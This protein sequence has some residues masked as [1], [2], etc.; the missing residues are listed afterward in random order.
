[1]DNLMSIEMLAKKLT[2]DVVFGQNN[3]FTF[4]NII[5]V[6]DEN[7]VTYPYIVHKNEDKVLALKDT[8]YMMDFEFE[9]LG[10]TKIISGYFSMKVGE[11]L[12]TMQSEDG[13]D[14]VGYTTISPYVILLQFFKKSEI[15]MIYPITYV[16]NN[17]DSQ[18]TD[19]TEGL[20]IVEDFMSGR[21]HYGYT[22]I[23]KNIWFK[24]ESRINLTG[25][26]REI[27]SGFSIKKTAETFAMDD[28]VD[29][30]KPNLS[31]TWDPTTCLL[32]VNKTHPDYEAVDLI[33]VD[34]YY[35]ENPEKLIEDNLKDGKLVFSYY[36]NMR[37]PSICTI[38]RD[39]EKDFYSDDD[40]RV[41]YEYDDFG[42][43]TAF[44]YYMDGKLEVS[45]KYHTAGKTLT[46]LEIE[47][48]SIDNT[49]I[50]T[51][52]SDPNY[53]SYFSMDCSFTY[54]GHVKN[55]PNLKSYVYTYDNLYVKSLAYN[56]VRILPL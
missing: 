27:N 48:S 23:F 51:C 8:T 45:A 46:L 12:Y 16:V 47:S 10:Y 21:H 39:K 49:I 50:W 5:Y 14:K 7:N 13:K 35:T 18:L 31:Y 6:A 4:A 26:D 1:M 9:N 32:S 40:I 38:N 30:S 25:S 41:E 42:I 56:N 54:N 29:E 33:G 20:V 11:M 22:Q 17:Y 28:L 2:R 37:E 3:E 52:N 55:I 36:Q 34:L 19:N 53:G 44:K 15:G 43:I 24:L